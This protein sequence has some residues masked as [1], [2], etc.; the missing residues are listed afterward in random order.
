MIFS[1]FW[2]HSGILGFLHVKF[3]ADFR[4]MVMACSG[5][6]FSLC[7]WFTY[8]TIIPPTPVNLG[9]I[10]PHHPLPVLNSPVPVA[11]GKVH[12]FTL[13]TL[14]EQRRFLLHHSLQT[15][16]FQVGT[17]GFMREGLIGDGLK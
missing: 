3:I 13:M 9:L 4:T 6:Q 16:L 12:P 17:D 14:G 15:S 2:Y 7:R 8:R 11:K 1:S 5:H 10:R